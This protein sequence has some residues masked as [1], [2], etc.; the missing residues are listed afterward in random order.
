M[1]VNEQYPTYWEKIFAENGYCM[2]DCIRNEFWEDTNVEW[3]YRQNV[4]IYCK[5]ECYEKIINLFASEKSIKDVVHPEV[6]ALSE[7]RRRIFPFDKVVSGSKVV[8]YGASNVGKEVMNQLHTTQ[9]AD[10]VLWCDGAFE[11]YA[12][13]GM[14]ISSP[15]TISTAEYDYVVIA[16]ESERTADSISNRLLE[17]GVPK[18]KIVW[19]Y[20]RII[21]KY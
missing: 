21:K 19:K 17:L 14:Q 11:Q 16:I 9:Y 3:F 7:N 8:I 13:M 2:C 20:P 15:D 10:V 4:M 1:H 5:E 6:F 18:D 12:G